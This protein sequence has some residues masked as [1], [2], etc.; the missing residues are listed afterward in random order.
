L[1][2]AS[3]FA[4]AGLVAGVAAAAVLAALAFFGAALSVAAVLLGALLEVTM[5]SPWGLKTNWDCG[6]TCIKSA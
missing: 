6:A 5:A 2:T 3:D 4:G 1:L